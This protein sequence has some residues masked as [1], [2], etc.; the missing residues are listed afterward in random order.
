MKRSVELKRTP[1]KPRLPDAMPKPPP[2]PRK[3]K[4]RICKE[5]FLPRN[6]THTACKPECA[7]EAAKL[8]REALARR[9]DRLRKQKLKSRSRW[10]GEAQAAFNAYIR[11]RDAALPC[12]SCGRHHEGA[13]DAGH[14]RS[15]GAMLALRFEELNVHKQC[16]PCNQHKAGNIVEYRIRLVDRIGLPMVE[17]LEQN[18]PPAKYTIEDAQRIKALYKQKL[19][20]LQ[21]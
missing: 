1:F 9:D 2:G 17:W 8:K 11:A 15:V 12:I 19:K 7:L 3:R 4:C 20:E 13:Y 10:L 5:H 18:H 16:V 14:Y 21:P 6:S